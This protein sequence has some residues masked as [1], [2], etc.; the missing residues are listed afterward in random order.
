MRFG[1]GKINL[2]QFFLGGIIMYEELKMTIIM[3]SSQDIVCMSDD[4]VGEWSDE[5]VDQEGWA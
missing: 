4:F 3:L 2:I 1:S 5:N